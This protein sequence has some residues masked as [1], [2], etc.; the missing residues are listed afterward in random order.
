MKKLYT[1]SPR[2]ILM[3]LALRA[4]LV[5]FN[6]N[7]Q[8][9]L[10][11]NTGSYLTG[12]VEEVG[13][14]EVKYRTAD[15]GGTIIRVVDR[16]TLRR[17]K[18]A[19][20]QTITVDNDPMS[21]GY[22]SAALARKHIVKVDFLSP[23]FNHITFGYEQMIKP[24]MNV[25]AKLGYIGLGING[26][27]Y[28]YSGFLAKVGMK[29]ISKPEFIM[30]GMRLSHPMRGRYI[31]PEIMFSSYTRKTDGYWQDGFFGGGYFQGP[32]S[33]HFTSVA[34]NVV[35]GKQAVLGEHFTTDWFVGVGYGNTWRGMDGYP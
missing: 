28:D 22:T 11:L 31:K 20:G 2:I 13:L 34:F 29:F 3:L 19:N 16:S 6:A 14:D 18:L 32:S 15:D 25:E 8:D 1:P 26:N 30:R 4:L 7:A 27:G 5:H 17:I 9:T 12:K 23:A 33:I 24:W 21:A 10:F 35:F